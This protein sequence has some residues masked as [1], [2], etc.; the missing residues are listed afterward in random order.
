MFAYNV[1][2]HSIT[3]Y[4]PYELMFGH[5]APA[6][7]LGLAHYNDKA[8]TSKCTWL[9]EQHVLLMTVNRPVLKHIRQSARKSQTRACGK[10]LHILIDNLVLLKDHP[11]GQNKI[12]DN[13]K[14]VLFIVAHHKDPNVYII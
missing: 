6:I 2:L 8:S 5:K 4:Q 7:C 9:N 14:S 12:Q 3:G 11:E 10:T 13:Y 1:M